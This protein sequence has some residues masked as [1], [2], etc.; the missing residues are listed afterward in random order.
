M[1]SRPCRQQQEQP[2]LA[3]P[4]E[5]TYD[6]AGVWS[7]MRKLLDLVVTEGRLGL[8]EAA[9]FQCGFAQVQDPGAR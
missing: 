2:P 8:A 6:E 9:A 1:Q 4:C 3:A 7:N 5:L